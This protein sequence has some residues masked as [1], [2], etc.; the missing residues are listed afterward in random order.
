MAKPEGR[1]IELPG[2]RALESLQRVTDAALAY[3]SEEDLLQ[4]L[5]QRISDIME[6]D[7]VAILLLEGEALHA[8]AAKGI[9]EEVEQGVRIPLGRGFAGR[10]AAERRAIT[11]PDVDHA[12]ILNPILREKGIKSL[13][14][15]PLIVEGTVLGVL[16]VGSLTP[17]DFSDEDRDLLQLAGDRAALAIEQARLYGRER[18]ARIAAER[19]TLRLQSLQRVTDAALAYLSEEDLLQELLQRISDIMEIDTVAILLLEGEALHARAAKGIEEEVEQGVRIPLGRGFAG[20]IAAERR[21]ITI[22]DVDHADILNPILREKG[23]KSLL[24]VPL[25][26]EGT[27]LG[28]LHVG[29]LTPRDFSDEDRDL[30]QLAGDRAALAIEQARLYEQR[31]VA[32]TM[33]R[34]LLPDRLSDV[35]GLEIAARYLPAA[36]G[37]LGGDWYDVFSLSGGRVAVA[38]GDVV[39]RGVEAA[40]VMAQLRTAVRAYAAD[41]HPPAA[42]LERVNTLMWHL[43]PLAMT[44]A[45]YAVLD[46]AAET[47]ELVSAGHPPA[48]VIPPSGAAAY[49]E[50]QPGLPLGVSA[51]VH[52]RVADVPPAHGRHP[53]ALHRRSRRAP[54]RVDR[55]GLERLRVLGEGFGDVEALCAS[56][57]ERLVGEE[58]SDDVAFVA[59]RVPPLTDH[60]TTRWPA[61]ADSLAAI[62][63]LLRRWL[64]SRGATDE[65]TYDI[66]VACQEACANAVEHAYGPGPARRDRARRRLCG[67][68]GQ[69]DRLRSRPLAAVAGREP[70]SRPPDDAGAHGHGRRPP[71]RR[72]HRRRPGKAPR[73]GDG[74]TL[75]AHITDERRGGLAVA[76]VEGEIDASNVKWVESRLRALL[77]NQSDGLVVDLS[78]TTY[79]DSAG[80]ALW[81]ALAED[82]RQ[83]QQQL[84]LVV[85]DRSS[86][87]RMV[88]LTGLDEAVPTHPTLEQAL[89]D[90]GR[91]GGRPS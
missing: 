57:V 13:L 15:V 51:D 73:D 14:G 62:R 82:L 89:N 46:P 18:L 29:S 40:A 19:A 47:L 21:A 84:R 56:V 65:E 26:V 30:L 72:R 25:I 1:S 60:L 61:T 43:G 87:A 76:R 88:T 44:T 16:H 42:V 79:L 10:I 52:L 17:R 20:R 78:A 54:G 85:V 69:R 80:I 70:R 64:G 31:R 86:I 55:L 68:P 77:T 33:Q 7:T 67:R 9:E 45:L 24:G 53:A 83:H 2:G 49:L 12:D 3:L 34:R 81:F 8:R 23:I 38:V 71:E 58:P 22:P 32:E 35:S 4:E 28:V 90:E 11:I 41:G 50:S 48:L 63:Y 36:G 6:I 66:V 39:G 27:V 75:L 37:S 91:P 5:L 74:V 59:A